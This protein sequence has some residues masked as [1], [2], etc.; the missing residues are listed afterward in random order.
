LL[1]V[2]CI[3]HTDWDKL[4]SIAKTSIMYYFLH[5]RPLPIKSNTPKRASFVTLL[6]N[7]QLRGCIGSIVPVR[8]LEEDVA[9]NAVQAAFYDPRFPPLSEDETPYLEI[10]VSVL[11]PMYLFEGT[12]EE[13][14]EFLKEKKPGVYIQCL[15]GSATFLPQVWEQIPDEKTFMEELSMKAGLPPHEWQYC[16]KYYYFVDEKK[17]HWNDIDVLEEYLKRK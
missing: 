7:G 8:P 6:K 1:K 13:F 9:Y 15:G 3:T 17:K 5:K 14:L 11:S 2:V 12:N 4:L 10:E 16:K